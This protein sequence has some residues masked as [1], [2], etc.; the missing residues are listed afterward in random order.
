MPPF[1]DIDRHLLALLQEDST[2]TL[3]SLGTIVGL[4][5]SAVK[6]RIDR[7]H[8]TGV[9]TRTVAV[10]DPRA[11]LIAICTVTL[12]RE[13]PAAHQEFRAHALANPHVQQLYNV[14]GDADYVVVLATTGM[15]QH[16]EV[17]DRVLKSAP[18]IRRYTTMFALDPVRTTLVLP[19]D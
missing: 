4:S 6:R 1:D 17:A 9:I 8:A 18:N 14:S 5:P 16:R 3:A 2:R 15:E 10:L 11:S 13:S 12:D 19:A 7:Y